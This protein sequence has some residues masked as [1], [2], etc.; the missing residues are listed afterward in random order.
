MPT[1]AFAYANY[2]I[3][4]TFKTA[5]TA[6]K[7]FGAGV[8]IGQLD[9]KNALKLIYGLGNQEASDYPDGIYQGGLTVDFDVCNPWWLYPVLGSK[10]VAGGSAP[11]TWTFT[12]ANTPPSITIECGVDLTT[13]AVQKFLGCVCAECKLTAEAEGGPAHASLTFLYANETKSSAGIGSQV[14]ETELAFN[15]GLQTLEVPSGTPIADVE[16]LEISIKRNPKMVFGLGSRFAAAYACGIREY[17]LNVVS[18]FDDAS[19]F[20]EKLYGA[21]GGPQS[22]SSVLAN[23]T[24]K[25]SNDGW[26]A[27]Q[28]TSRRYVWSFGNTKVDS[29]SLPMAVE[30]VLMETAVLKPLTMTS[31]AVINAIGTYP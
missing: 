26:G 2:G 24:F 9:R 3:E 23:L 28:A 8:K 7:T 22:V 6:N 25:F 16:R 29:H 15:M 4:T 10:S 17:E 13:D 31:V 19:S 14:A 12:P 1:G 21:A 5:V 27:A 30:D 11:Y 20:L 18:S